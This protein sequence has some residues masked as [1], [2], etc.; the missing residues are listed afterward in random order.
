MDVVGHG[1]QMMDHQD[2]TRVVDEIG[3]GTM[4]TVTESQTEK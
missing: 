4:V 1:V 2:G 3:I